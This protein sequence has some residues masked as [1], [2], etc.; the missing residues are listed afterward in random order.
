MDIA[1]ATIVGALIAVAGSIIINH[2]GNVLNNYVNR[3]GYKI[4]QIENIAENLQKDRESDLRK[5]S[6]LSSDMKI[7][8]ESI[9]NLSDFT[10]IMKTLNEENIILKSE[11]QSLIRENEQLKN[12]LSQQLKGRKTL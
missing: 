12:Q 4:K 3:K 11:N 10:S 6:F 7:I 9:A 5:E 2:L 1:L 8:N